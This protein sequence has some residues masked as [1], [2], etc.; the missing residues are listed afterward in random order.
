MDRQIEETPMPLE[1]R[2]FEMKII[3]NDCLQY[4]RVKFHIVGGKC[5]NCRSYNTTRTGDLI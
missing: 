5:S 3:C 1:Y 2:H 4:S